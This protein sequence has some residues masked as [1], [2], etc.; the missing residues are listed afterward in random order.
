MKIVQV[1]T[2]ISNF[3]RGG[4]QF[5]LRLSR[6]LNQLSHEV[7]L[8]TGNN[9]DVTSLNLPFNAIQ[10]S[11]CTSKIARKLLF[12]YYNYRAVKQFSSVLEQFNPD[13]V[14]FHSL[15]GLSSYLVY[16]S[17]RLAP[18]VVTLHDMWPMYVDSSAVEPKYGLA[19][20]YWKVP[21]GFVH[22]NI[23]RFLYARASL[24]SP[25]IWLKQYAANIGIGDNTVH[26]ANGIRHQ[27]QATIYR[28]SIIWVGAIR[29]NKGLHTVIATIDEFCKSSGWDFHVL[30]D[31]PLRPQ[32]EKMYPSVTFHGHVD[33]PE[34]FYK[35]SSILIVSSIC[36]EN[37]PTV[38]LEGMAF[39]LCVIGRNIAGI[40]EIICH[41]KTGL[42][43]SSASD[44]HHLL[45]NLSTNTRELRRIG[46]VAIRAVRSDYSIDTC[47]RK[48][49]GHF[50]TL[51]NSS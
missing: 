25:S 47:V 45:Y 6:N 21:L 49:I 1:C 14:H 26:I 29:P 10:I 8:V 34:P 5:C 16:V 2:S 15:Y 28:E 51:V 41:N 4:E 35:Q 36:S 7:L 31:G 13:I 9:S 44:L 12:D 11:E 18:T 46:A 3:Q 24:V 33:N 32:L 50:R 37:L 43:F 20:S 22:R 23:N 38:V 39:G 30:G 27:L 17:A 42:L 48:Y 19:N 40:A